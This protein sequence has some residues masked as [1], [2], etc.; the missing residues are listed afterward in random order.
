LRQHRLV[1]RA[2]PPRATG[3]L[4]APESTIEVEITVGGLGDIEAAWARLANFPAQGQWAEELEPLIVS[5][6][7]RWSVYRPVEVL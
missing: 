7:A 3:S 6:T 5:G 1:G 4:G 2:G